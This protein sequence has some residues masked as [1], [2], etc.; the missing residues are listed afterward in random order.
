VNNVLIFLIS[1]IGSLDIY[2]TYMAWLG[3][4]SHFE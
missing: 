2:R 3:E 1:S 4:I